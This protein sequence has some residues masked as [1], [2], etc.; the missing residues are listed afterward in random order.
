MR[1][2]RFNVCGFATEQFRTFGLVTVTGVVILLSSCHRYAQP[3]GDPAS[4]SAINP[5]PLA[6]ARADDGQWLM[7]T[8]DYANQGNWAV[9]VADNRVAIAAN[10]ACNELSGA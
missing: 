9:K 7:A 8:K 2:L 5:A 1:Q 10:L 6:Q 4:T 3:K